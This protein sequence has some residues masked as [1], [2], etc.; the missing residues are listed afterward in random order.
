MDKFIKYYISLGGEKKKDF[1]TPDIA[2]I[3]IVGRASAYI[4]R[5]DI[6]NYQQIA[7]RDADAD[8]MRQWWGEAVNSLIPAIRRY[9]KMCNSEDGAVTLVLAHPKQSIENVSVQIANAISN[10]FGYFL[11]SKWC[12]I[13]IA[14]Q[15]QVYSE[16]ATGELEKLKMLLD[17]RRRPVPYEM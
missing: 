8:I 4:G 10:Y 15:A 5:T 2:P 7:V 16:V 9:V 3:D 12:L 14:A 17:D 6:E 1:I 13:N 11:L